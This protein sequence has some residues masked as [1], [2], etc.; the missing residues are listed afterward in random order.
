MLIEEG[1]GMGMGIG[2]GIGIEIGIE[3]TLLHGH[4]LF[5]ELQKHRFIF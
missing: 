4:F 2:M 3:M 5:G 1:M